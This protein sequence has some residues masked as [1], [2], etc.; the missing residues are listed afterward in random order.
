[1][2]LNEAL[3]HGLS[4]KEVDGTRSMVGNLE[5]VIYEITL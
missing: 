3:V 5:G 4:M 2:V 1:M